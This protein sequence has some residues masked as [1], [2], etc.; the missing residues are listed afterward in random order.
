M[1]SGTCEA[2]SDNFPPFSRCKLPF[3]VENRAATNLAGCIPTVVSDPHISRFL[4][5]RYQAV[6]L[7]PRLDD[8]DSMILFVHDTFVLRDR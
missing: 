7:H 6:L 1:A 2:W 5:D 4:A 3:G 8:L